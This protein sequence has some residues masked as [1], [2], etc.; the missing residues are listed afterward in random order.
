[1]LNLKPDKYYVKHCFLNFSVFDLYYLFKTF[2][3][4]HQEAIFYLENLQY[5]KFI[6]EFYQFYP[7]FQKKLLLVPTKIDY[8]FLTFRS[9]E[10]NNSSNIKLFIDGLFGLKPS[11]AFDFAIFSVDDKLVP[12]NVLSLDVDFSRDSNKNKAQLAGESFLIGYHDNSGTIDFSK[13]YCYT[14][15]NLPTD[16]KNEL[17]NNCDIELFLHGDKSISPIE[18]IFSD[19]SFIFFQSNTGTGSSGGPIMNKSGELIALNT[20]NYC[21]VEEKDSLIFDKNDLTQFDIEVTIENRFNFDVKKAKNFNIAIR[22]QHPLIVSYFE[23]LK[24]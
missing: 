8:D 20:G 11:P 18:I 24:I 21:D 19:E 5:D 10:L 6:D 22:I 17:E 23:Q 2:V 1:M 9:K 13:E 15:I 14:F 16:V 3:K 12:K 7:R 4:S